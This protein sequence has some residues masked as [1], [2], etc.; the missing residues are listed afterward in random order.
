[1]IQKPL[2]SG[3]P[4]IIWLATCASGLAMQI[5]GYEPTVNDRFAS[6]FPSNP[7]RNNH[8]NLIGREYW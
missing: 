2:C 7:V 5:V 8:E 1:M 6:G 3:I 4:V